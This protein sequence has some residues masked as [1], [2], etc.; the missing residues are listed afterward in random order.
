MSPL[1]L[2]P[3][4][5]AG[6][7]LGP[8]LRA[9][10][11]RYAVPAGEPWLSGCP[12]CGRALR[13]WHRL[14]AVTSPAGRCAGCRA[15][16]GP[17]PYVIEA[18]TALLFVALGWRVDDPLPLA[19]SGW[20][21]AT[22]VALWCIDVRVQRLPDR[23]TI[24]AFGAVLALLSAA[25]FVAGEPSAAGRVVLNG[26]GLAG[27]YLVLF[28]IYP[29]GIGLGDAKLGL[30]LG[31]LLGWYGGWA[32]TVFGAAMGFVTSGLVAVVLLVSGRIGRKDSLPHGPFMLLGALT[33]VLLLG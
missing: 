26:L 3:L 10:V 23:L 32:A 1:L 2:A 21:A 27:G 16:I 20:V 24:S 22:G 29:A 33:M 7:A 12:A 11:V 17:P 31:A 14:P 28:L 18:V 30:S 13:R 4:A 25:A 9:L 8:L 5:V 19:A 6:A 15:R